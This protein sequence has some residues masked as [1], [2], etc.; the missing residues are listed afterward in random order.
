[1]SF[2]KSR[3]PQRGADSSR[4]SA[5]ASMMDYSSATGGGGTPMR[6]IGFGGD[7]GAHTS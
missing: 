1:M 4:H 5:A 6:L 3:T 7:T 2:Y